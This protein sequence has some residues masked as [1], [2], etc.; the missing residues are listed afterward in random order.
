M[1][2]CD[3]QGECNW[4][5]ELNRVERNISSKVA[6]YHTET[7]QSIAAVDAR[8][9]KARLALENKIGEEL[10]NGTSRFIQIAGDIGDIKGALGLK[11]DKTAIAQ[12]FKEMKA[13]G[14]AKLDRITWLIIGMLSSG[15]ISLAIHLITK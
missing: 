7:K 2:P 11:A 6:A 15:F 12:D 1:R 8:H 14:Q 10:S 13:S 4:K 5:D 3:K 9:E